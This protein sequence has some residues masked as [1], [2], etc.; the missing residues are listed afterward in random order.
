MNEIKVTVELCAED[1]ARLDK[2]TAALENYTPPIIGVDLAQA[3]EAPQA[4]AEPEPAEETPVEETAPK[5]THDMIH[6]RVKELIA[7]GSAA[8]NEAAR[9]AVTSRARNISGLPVEC[10]AEVW[11]ELDALGAPAKEA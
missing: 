11:A 1:R 7:N 6:Q 10:L 2:L 5:I 8:Q 9:K 4:V 3:D